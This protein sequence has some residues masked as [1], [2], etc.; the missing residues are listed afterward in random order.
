MPGRLRKDK[1]ILP[2]SWKKH[3]YPSQTQHANTVPLS[4]RAAPHTPEKYWPVS[5][6]FR[7]ARVVLS[8]P[9]Y[10]LLNNCSTPEIPC[11][12]PAFERELSLK[13]PNSSHCVAS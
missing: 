1:T 5:L 11:S 2:F 7:P 8:T 4:E 13:F 6:L 10:T 3:I 9:L 12:S